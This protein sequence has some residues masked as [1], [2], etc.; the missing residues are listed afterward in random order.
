MTPEIA[1]REVA[2]ARANGT[3]ATTWDSR[4]V[5]KS[6]PEI[7][8]D[9]M[10]ILAD[11]PMTTPKLRNTMGIRSQRM[12]AILAAMEDEGLVKSRPVVIDGQSQLGWRL[13]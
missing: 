12:Y 5:A 10:R 3:Y 8:K 9:V 2:A 13:V 7:R 1:A 4:K 11:A 6:V